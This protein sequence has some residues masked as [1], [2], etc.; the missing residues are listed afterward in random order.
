MFPAPNQDCTALRWSWHLT[1][2]PSSITTH[3][4]ASS[5]PSPALLTCSTDSWPSWWWWW[6][7]LCKIWSI[8]AHIMLSSVH[9][10]DTRCVGAGYEHICTTVGHCYQ[11]T[12]QLQ[13]SHHLAE[14]HKII[15]DGFSGKSFLSCFITCYA[16]KEFLKSRVRA[17]IF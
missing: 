13:M 5:T 8:F 10:S 14:S 6:T 3:M 7:L 15:G 12:A 16:N 17:K 4:L 2:A 11:D 9:I 1:L